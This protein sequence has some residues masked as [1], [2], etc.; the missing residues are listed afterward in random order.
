MPADICRRPLNTF[1]HFPK[2]LIRILRGWGFL[3]KQ[4]S[5]RALSRVTGGADLPRKG[6]HV[7]IE[8]RREERS[9]SNTVFGSVLLRDEENFPQ[10]VEMTN[11]YRGGEVIE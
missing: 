11:E 4:A 6:E 5:S 8:P 1:L 3:A 9:W 2:R 10:D 7:R